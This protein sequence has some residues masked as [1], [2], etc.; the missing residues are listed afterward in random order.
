MAQVRIDPATLHREQEI[1]LKV[2]LEAVITMRFGTV[3]L[4]V[5]EGRVTQ[6][7]KLEKIRL[8]GNMP[9]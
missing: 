7:E 4:V 1:V 6:I 2:A 5:H 3:T 9:A 8:T